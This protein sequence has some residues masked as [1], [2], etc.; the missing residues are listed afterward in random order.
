M[1]ITDWRQIV[2][3]VALVGGGG[4]TVF[5]LVPWS[6]LVSWLSGRRA[7]SVNFAAERI[8]PVEQFNQLIFE[9]HDHLTG[10]LGAWGPDAP[11][12]EHVRR[13]AAAL[14][15]SHLHSLSTLGLAAR[16]A[17]RRLDPEL[18]R[19]VQAM[20]AES[21]NLMARLNS[22]LLHTQMQFFIERNN[23]VLALHQRVADR[24]RELLG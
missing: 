2:G 6:A 17:A 18:E 15:Q 9:V 14:Y 21:A 5:K 4:F 23:K 22:T 8:Q 11:Y 19:R 24:V 16:E 13:R 1:D 20:E 12:D 3:M 10:I 7:R